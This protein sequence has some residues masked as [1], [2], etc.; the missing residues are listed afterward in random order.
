MN[1]DH[2]SYQRATTVSVIGLLIQGVLATV[3]LLYGLFGQDIAAMNGSF[4]MFLGLPIWVSLALVFHQHKLERLEA[5][6]AEAFRKS[7]AA[8]ASVFEGIGQDQT[9][10]ASRLAW[11]HKWFLPV[12]SLVVGGAYIGLG[13][14]LWGRSRV[15]L[16]TVEITGEPSSGWAIAVGVGVAVLAFIFA[17]FVAGMAK[18]K[19]WALLHAG[20][21]SGVL[22]SLV[23]VS[24]V[25]AHFVFVVLKSQAGLRYLP[26]AMNVAMF[27]LGAE[28][29]LHFV[30]NLYRP[31]QAGVWLRPAFDSRV[32]AFLAAPDRLAASLSEAVN[33]QF[34][35]NVSSTWFYR[36]LAR[37]VMPLVVLV[38]LTMW[39][40]TCLV[41]VKPDQ[42]GLVLRGGALVEEVG[43]G[44]VFKK[45]WP[46]DEVLVFPA[47]SVNE[48]TVGTPAPN[49]PDQPILWTN[50][51]AGEE[52]LVIVQPW[53]ARRGEQTRDLALLSVE[54]PVHYVVTDLTKY[55]KIAQDS[56]GD[57]IERTRRELLTAVASSVVIKHLA[58]YPV[59]VLLGDGRPGVARDLK[60]AVQA[61]FDALGAGVHIT[62]LG[63]AGVHPKQDVAPAFEE[64]VAKDQIKEATIEAAR[65]SEIETLAAVAGD[66]AK[67]REIIAALEQLSEARERQPPDASAVEALE[68]RVMTL[69]ERAGGEAASMI[70]RAGAA[71]WQRSIGERAKAVRSQGQIASYRAAPRAY[72]AGLYLD[73]IRG[74][75]RGAKVYISPFADL[76]VQ[77]NYEEIEPDVSGFRAAKPEG[78]GSK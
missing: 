26:I 17:R 45:P 55:Q 58:T 60:T 16:S 35:F 40:L 20:S 71:R 61:A 63:V 70:S 23:G 64:V 12:M 49:K 31:R 33:Y 30:L 8:Q 56:S 67:A 73:A 78:E 15:F 43:P 25:V 75:A 6:E 54:V 27:A 51:H 4:A 62:F 9:V 37:S 18:Q 76:E 34:G 48:L 46:M 65:K 3:V 32:L 29:L 41:V 77:G 7:A 44:L 36:L 74:G 42:K 52:T 69:I 47:S 2:L 10:H 22:C 50:Q 13:A 21:A 39:A 1:A 68:D 5:L 38:V 14:W 72:K 57:D 24:L 53:G 11:M 19:V 66:V 28:V 59:D